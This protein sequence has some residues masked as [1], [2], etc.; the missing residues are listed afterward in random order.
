MKEILGWLITIEDRA[1]RCYE[2]AADLFCED[3]ELSRFLSRLAKA[4]EHHGEIIRDIAERLK[5]KIQLPFFITL[6]DETKTKIEDPLTVFERAL[7]GK[8]L[9]RQALFEHMIAV[10]FS[11]L[12]DIFLCT[13]N[14]AKDSPHKFPRVAPKLQ[15]HKRSIERFLESD[16]S[17]K[18]LVERIRGYSP[19]WQENIL[20]VHNS[21]SIAALF[22]AILK[23]EGTVECVKNGEE[24]LKK[25]AQN[26]YAAIIACVRM[27]VMDGIE[28]YKKAVKLYPQMNER[29]IF[30]S[31]S[32]KEKE[33]LFFRANNLKC[34]VHPVPVNELRKAVADVLDRPL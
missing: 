9:T 27:P 2:E 25:L 8:K 26:Y 28:F 7:D 13:I 12:N 33:S 31:D 22:A 30:C 4:E 29:I 18:G 21:E 5:D 11:E 23:D 17:L 24:A 14:A 34:L 1:R 6:D 20:V 3:K 19:V 15:Q 32:V 16:P 10:E